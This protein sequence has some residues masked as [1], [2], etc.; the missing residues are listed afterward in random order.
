MNG[1][2]FIY[3]VRTLLEINNIVF[4]Y[5]NRDD[6]G[7]CIGLYPMPTAQYEAVDYMGNLYI[8]FIFPNG[9]TMVQSWEDLAVLRKDYNSSDIWG[10]SNDAIFTSLDLLNTMNQGTANAI[11]STANLRGILIS[12]KAML[13]PEDAKKQK[14]QFVKDYMDMTTNG[15]GIASLSHTRRLEV[16]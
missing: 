4:V 16:N 9:K 12:K 2:D 13:S 15:S 3:K 14:D 6:T 1:K 11:K 5:I 10:D 8:K 7:R